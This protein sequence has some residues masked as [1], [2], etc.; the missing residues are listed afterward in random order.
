MGAEGTERLQ[1]GR[2][3]KLRLLKEKIK[4]SERGLGISHSGFHSVHIQDKTTSMTTKS[5]RLFMPIFK[6]GDTKSKT[7]SWTRH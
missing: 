7:Q 3:I 2:Q 5:K 1:V 4:S 6:L